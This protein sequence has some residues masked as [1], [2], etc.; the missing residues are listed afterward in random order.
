MAEKLKFAVAGFGDRGYSFIRPLLT[1]EFRDQAEIVAVLDSNPLKLEFA[2]GALKTQPQVKYFTDVRA[3]MREDADLVMITPPQFAHKELA[4]AAL[5]AGHNIFLEK[6]MARTPAECRAIIEAEKRSGKTVFM[7]FNLRH[8][9]VCTRMMELLPKIGHVQQMICTDFYSG[10]YS[11]FRRWHRLAANSGGLSVEKGCHSIDLLNLFAGSTPVRVSAFGGL[12]RF[13]PDPEGAD[14]CSNCGKTDRCSFYMDIDKAEE[15]T[16]L[17]TGIPG[18]IV[19]G[20]KKMD[21]CVFNSDKDTLDNTTIIIEYANGC[22]AVLAECFTSSVKRTS[23]REFILN[24]WEGQLWSG[25]SDRTIRLYPH[26]PTAEGPEP[27]VEK[28][29]ETAGNH[30]GADNIMLHYVIDCLRHGKPNRKMLTRDGYYA[31]ATAAAAEQAI[32]E[33]RIVEIEPL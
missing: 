25:L 32:R 14:Y 23:G 12:D 27:Q 8:H 19:N 1:P 4:C 6:P 17:G 2:R 29:P 10:G 5:E 28:I 16:R 26:C 31:V 21:L 22:R 3:F 33:R 30:G 24:G 15:L 7:G 18:I 11:Y 13:T 9:P 20:G